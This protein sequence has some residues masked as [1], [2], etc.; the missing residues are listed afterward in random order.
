MSPTETLEEKKILYEK[1]QQLMKQRD[2]SFLDSIR[3][4]IEEDLTNDM[5]ASNGSYQNSVTKM[6]SADYPKQPLELPNSPLVLKSGQT[7]SDHFDSVDIGNS[8]AS[9]QHSGRSQQEHGTD[10][11]SSNPDLS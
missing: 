3:Q 11:K 4:E 7:E 8:L 1:Q 10:K 9:F 2:S 6:T 5:T